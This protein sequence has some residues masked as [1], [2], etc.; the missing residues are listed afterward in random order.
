MPCKHAG[1]ST[2]RPSQTGSR[3]PPKEQT[4]D[5]P[6]AG[7]CMALTGLLGGFSL[8]HLN[9]PPGRIM[10]EVSTRGGETRVRD[11]KVKEWPTL[12]K[13]IARKRRTR[14]YFAAP[15]STYK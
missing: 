1:F 2:P 12:S 13:I 7:N 10:A 5:R 11:E 8:Q 15:R 3:P 9:T 6:S 14:V 4:R